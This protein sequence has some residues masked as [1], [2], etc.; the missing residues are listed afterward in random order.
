MAAIPERRESH[1]VRKEIPLKISVEEADFIS[2]TQNLSQSGA[3][4]RIKKAIPTMTHLAITLLIPSIGK[5][6][7][8][9]KILCNGVVVRCEP[10]TPQNPAGEHQIGIYFTGM[11]EADRKTLMQFAQQAAQ[12]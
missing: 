1:R 11:K 8:T 12:P 5:R 7:T 3:F 2:Q 4:F 9:K 6:K 10:I